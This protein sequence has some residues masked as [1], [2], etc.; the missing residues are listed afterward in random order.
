MVEMEGSK[1]PYMH[2]EFEMAFFLFG[3]GRGG[4]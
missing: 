4:K 3:G 2:F 1:N